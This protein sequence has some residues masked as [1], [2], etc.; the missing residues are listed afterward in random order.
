MSV[1]AYTEDQLVEQPA[2]GLFAELGCQTVS[3]MEE[4]FGATGTLLRETEG[5]VVLVSRLRAAL[6]RLVR[7]FPMKMKIIN[8]FGCLL[9]AL[10]ATAADSL[11]QN[12][13]QPPAE[14]R[15]WVYWFWNNGN[16]TSN[17]IT[18]DLEAMQRV[19]IGGVLIMDVVERFAPPRG[20][21]E[22]MNAE[23]RNLFQFSVQ[24]AAR[25]GLEINMANGPGWCGSSGPWITPELSMQ[26]LVST[27]TLVEGPANFSA[28]LP[29]PDTGGRQRH[30]SFDS[31]IK[32][33]DFYRDIAVLAFPDTTNGIVPPGAVT[34]LT[35]KL[36]ASGRLTW[37]VPPGRWIIQRI[38]H[39]T[40]GSST[41][42]PVVGGNGL[43]CDKLSA[44]AMTVHFTNMMGR[45]LQNAGPLAGKSLVATHIDSW[46][47]GSQNW[48]PK[49]RGEFQKRRGYD[50]LPWLPCVT[51]SLREKVNNKTTTRYL[52]NP[53][54]PELA[55]RFRWDF[56]QTIAELLAEN[57]SGRLA[58]LAHEHGLRYSLEGYTLPFGDEFTYTARTDEPMTE[59]WTGNKFNPGYT[60]ARA[61]QAAS[62][63]HVYGHAIVGAEAFTSGDKEMWK[64]TP[65]NIKALGDF[66]FSQGVNRF[67]VHR[68]AH[69]PYLD[70]APGVTMGP[71]GLHYERTQTWWEMSGAWHEYL[72]RCQYLLRQGNFVADLLC[73][74][75]EAPD[76]TTF[77]P[78]LPMP[79]GYRWD[80]ISAEALIQLA[81]V[82]D[83]RIVL[84]DGMTYR[85]LV[86]PPAKTMKPALAGKIRKLVSDGATI[87]L[88][89]PRP[90]TSP[91][92]ADFPKGDKAVARITG[93]VWGDC[94][95]KRV[96]EHALRK[97]RVIWGQPLPDVLAKLAKGADFTSDA[98][99]NWI[100]RHTDSAEIYFVANPAVMSVEAKCRF[101]VADLAPEL[102]NP[103]T[104]E[105]APLAAY[106]T[107]TG[108]ISIPLNF[109]P[110]G[111]AFV[112]FRKRAV[113]FD[114]LV[115]LTRDGE[116]VFAAVK[117]AAIEIQKATYGVPGDAQR[118]RDVRAKL[119]TMVNDGVASLAV[120]EL[121][122]GDDPAYG[123]VKTLVVE[124]IANGHRGK[125][126]GQDP[127]TISLTPPQAAAERA[128]EVCRDANGQLSMKARQPGHYELK[129]SG[130]QTR[131]AEITTVPAPL[132]ITGAWNVSF[133]P[134]WGAPGKITLDSLVSWSDSSIE[135][136][137]YFSGTATYT[138]TFD[139]IKDE[140]SGKTKGET[141]LDLGDVQGM[142]QVKL[143][144]HDLGVLWQPPFR[145]NVTGALQPGANTLEIRV[146]NLWPNRM[147]GDSAL[148]ETNRFTW[149]SWQPFTKDMPLLKSGLLGP[150]QIVTLV[151]I[152][153]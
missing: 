148:A 123:V 153:L 55:G 25:L 147:I 80:Q 67:V 115:G 29:S 43:E 40:T 88:N 30:D 41:R 139:W 22:F 16:V 58:G 114:S 42:P 133:P 72:A 118:T 1:H 91:S 81:T 105:I 4:T 84:P 18:A 51:D 9:V 113:A 75:P 104:G 15:P 21:A 24:E 109:E 13:Q 141:W 26:M 86:L 92:L 39:T 2:I 10:N 137:K 87:L 112:V 149:S 46:E 122:Q 60:D 102:W 38:G 129:T 111:S 134:K 106:E 96:T 99:L 57:Y 77:T 98:K 95:G 110:S 74:R 103:K 130:G 93:E 63:A 8:L 128:A 132:E 146:A 69:Q 34:N 73:L 126:S 116:S 135:G 3:A 101:R 121:A 76:Q 31:S 62:V 94:D 5:E 145:V 36:D 50:P 100:H 48:T 152:K 45:L 136:V 52:H 89:S 138:K 54:S 49:F 53:G 150:V 97:G 65:A 79:S 140:A 11:E 20:S 70:R 108:G 78:D 32:Y 142:A 83:G 125:I 47:V 59:F 151:P 33:E 82:K 68:Y 64:A 7:L 6:E 23:W 117:P 131:R 44:E 35:V 12:F 144:G 61:Q 14:A 28:A 143:N 17:G 27:N 107:T 120:A 37:G 85:V 66:E 124:Y 19:G 71:W 119:Q 90:Q 56:Q 127:D